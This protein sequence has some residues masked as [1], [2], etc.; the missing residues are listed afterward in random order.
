[1]VPDAVMGDIYWLQEDDRLGI[2]A[3]MYRNATCFRGTFQECV[4]YCGIHPYVW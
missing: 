3:V 2:W 4:A 1:M